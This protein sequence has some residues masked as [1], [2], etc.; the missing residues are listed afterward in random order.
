MRPGTAIA[1]ILMVIPFIMA[2]G[3]ANAKGPFGQRGPGHHLEHFLQREAEAL[4]LDT[5]TTAAIQQLVE[6]ARERA[7]GLDDALHEARSAMHDLLS[8]DVA[9]EEAV[10]RQAEIIGQIEIERSKHR[11]K[12]LIQV[13]ALLTPEQRALLRQKREQRHETL[14][15]ACAADLEAF[16]PDVEPGPERFRCLRSRRDD[17]SAGCRETVRE[18]KKELRRGGPPGLP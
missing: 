5:E 8:Q 16:C 9:D 10:M 15:E 1:A 14:L 13:H 11:L 6:E 4:G 12:A 18:A 17:V 7:R 3:P 2:P